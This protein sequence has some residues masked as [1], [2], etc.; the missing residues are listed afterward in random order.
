MSALT[1]FT[2][3][4]LYSNDA[5]SSS[6][7]VGN[8]G[9]IRPNLN[10]DGSVRRLVVMTALPTARNAAENPYHDRVE[11]EILIYTGKGRRG[12][13]SPDGLNAR[14]TAQ[15]AGR[16]PIWCFRQ[17]YSRR[18]KTRGNA[19]WRFLGLLSLLRFYRENQLDAEGRMRS[20]W[21][22]EFDIG[23]GVATVPTEGD[24]LLA[25][26][27]LSR[28]RNDTT[29]AALPAPEPTTDLAVE[30]VRA[31]L[32]ALHPRAFE[33]AVRQAFEATGYEDVVVTRYSQDGGIDVMAS[34][35]SGGW[36]VR[37][38]QIQVQAKR[39]LHTVGRKDV[40]E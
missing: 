37:R 31:R 1:E 40:A 19:R 23:S 33:Y 39:W 9:G 20:A 35:G 6:L 10:T 4:H 15:P 5:I 3:D 18:D 38:C 13:Q 32:L 11:G 36:P 2:V 25:E 28:P 12:D 27:L 21:V 7:G 29:E 30:Q 34:F 26:V 8:A 17:E 24:T 14:L 22:F 16:F